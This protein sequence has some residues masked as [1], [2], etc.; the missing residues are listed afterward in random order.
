MK[1]ASPDETNS[2]EGPKT[3]KRK[4][5]QNAEVEQGSS[6]KKDENTVDESNL[7]NELHPQTETTNKKTKRKKQ[8]SGQLNNVDDAS[9]ISV[10]QENGS[11]APEEIKD[12]ISHPNASQIKT[13]SNG[14]IIEELEYGNDDSK[15]ACKGKKASLPPNTRMHFSRSFQLLLHLPSIPAGQN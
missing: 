2:K 14:L 4:K 5:E 10:L 12:S 7:N 3:K 8:K 13:L 6:L 9:P 15:L 11:A 1:R